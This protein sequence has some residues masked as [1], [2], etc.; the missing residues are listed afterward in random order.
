MNVNA[1]YLKD[2]D[3]N[4][5]S[6]VT[7]A[8]TVYD[9]S[10]MPL[11]TESY[12][13]SIFYGISS[14]TPDSTRTKIGFTSYDYTNSNI[15]LYNGTFTVKVDGTYLVN[16]MIH[17]TTPSSTSSNIR[18]FAECQTNIKN[19]ELNEHYIKYRSNDN[20]QKMQKRGLLYK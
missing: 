19:S 14:T 10:D 1:K 3:N 5:I 9:K 4:I 6:P 11:S 18:I 2:E 16:I 12:F 8:N 13:K 17:C 15:E 20:E 7:S